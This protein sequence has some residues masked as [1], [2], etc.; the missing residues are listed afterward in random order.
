[1]KTSRS[2]LASN[3]DP[4]AN[5]IL[6]HYALKYPDAFELEIVDIALPSRGMELESS[7]LLVMN[8][9]RA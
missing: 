8:D 7:S 1:V 4:S 9:Q 6:H 3:G 2:I 5:P